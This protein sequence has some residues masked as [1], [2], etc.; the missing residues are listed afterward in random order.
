MRSQ[1]IVQL[2]QAQDLCARRRVQYI[3]LGGVLA[4]QLP[5]RPTAPTGSKGRSRL[6]ARP[7]RAQS[8]DVGI[9]VPGAGQAFFA[10]T[11]G[12]ETGHYYICY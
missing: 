7:H 5:G 2:R 12:Y 1:T 6:T 3:V 4:G 11:Q 10:N 9:N 8:Y